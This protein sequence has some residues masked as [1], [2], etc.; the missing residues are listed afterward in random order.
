MGR[1]AI[2]SIRFVLRVIATPIIVLAFGMLWIW[3]IV[4]L[5]PVFSLINFL[6]REPLGLASVLEQLN[7]MFMEPLRDT[8]ASS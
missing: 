8:W 1:I 6:S 2:E 5:L 4:F 7:E 3:G